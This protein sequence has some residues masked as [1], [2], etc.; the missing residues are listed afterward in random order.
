MHPEFRS[1]QVSFL[2][3]CVLLTI[4]LFGIHSY[5]LYYFAKD[6]T[7]F[8]PIYHIYIFHFLVTTLLYTVINYRFSKGK[9]D[10]FNLF[11][12]STLLKMV[13]VILFLLPLILSDFD[14][15]QPDVFNFFIPYFIY[16]FFEV[17]L[18]TKI[19][20]EKP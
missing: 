15:K 4:V 12:V 20:N 2:L 16:L 18:I 14:K 19:L 9:T 5:L 10:I 11:M 17:V 8:F 3:L 1:R 13:L 6:V 7:L